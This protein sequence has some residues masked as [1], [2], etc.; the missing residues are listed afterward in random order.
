MRKLDLG[1]PHVWLLSLWSPNENFLE[2]A[3]AWLVNY[4]FRNWRPLI[5]WRPPL[6]GGPLGRLGPQ[7]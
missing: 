5:A 2:E 7:W 4:R 6:N 3:L 1:V